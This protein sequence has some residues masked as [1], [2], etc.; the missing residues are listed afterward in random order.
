MKMNV[1]S[2]DRVARVV[3]GAGLVAWALVGGPLWAWIGIMPIVTGAI[4]Y[5]P[6]YPMFGINTC[7]AK[8]E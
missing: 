6:A 3:V 7:S 2:I 8:K 1:G 4:G 5:C